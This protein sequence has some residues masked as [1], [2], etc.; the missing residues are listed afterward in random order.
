MTQVNIFGDSH[1]LNLKKLVVGGLSTN[2]YKYSAASVKGLCNVNS[3][4]KIG[5]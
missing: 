1:T 2:I 4:L 3:K 5:N